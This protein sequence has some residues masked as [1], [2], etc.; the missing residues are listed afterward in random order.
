MQYR[1]PMHRCQSI[2]TIPSSLFQVAFVGQTFT[3][4]GLSQWLQKTR[5]GFSA[6]LDSKYSFSRSGKVFSK[7]SFQIHL[8]SCRG[9]LML[10]TLC[11]AWQ[12]SMH[13]RHSGR[14]RHLAVSTTMAKRPAV[15]SEG[16]GLERYFV[17]YQMIT[18]DVQSLIDQ[19]LEIITGVFNLLQAY[20]ALGLVVGIAG[21][22]VITM[23]NVVERRQ[24]TGALRALGFRKSM[25][26]KSYLLELSFVS[27]TGILLGSAVGV[28]LTYDL[29]L[30]FFE[31][32]AVFAIPW[33]RLLLLGGIAFLGSVLATAS[34][35]IRASRLPPA[36]ALRSFE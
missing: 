2:I 36:E 9:S 7:G 34:P 14:A 10:G 28:A 20:L 16:H 15:T 13:S 32:Q 33:A 24:E 4:G 19:I 30:R 35:A 27:L 23:R 3:H 25:V 18:I 17:R 8:I 6:R 22:G 26:L 21:L 5:T 31:G 1:Q 12:A 11:A 29:F